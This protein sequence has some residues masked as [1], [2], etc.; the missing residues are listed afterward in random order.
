MSCRD[1]S[2]LFMIADYNKMISIAAKRVCGEWRA[3]GGSGSMGARRV[4][5]GTLEIALLNGNVEERW[6]LIVI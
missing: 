3:M 2:C 4:G 5:G 1:Y 6:D